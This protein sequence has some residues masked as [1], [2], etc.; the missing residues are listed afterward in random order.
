[1]SPS[2]TVLATAIFVAIIALASFSPAKSQQNTASVDASAMATQPADVEPCLGCH[3]A[4]LAGRPGRTPSL[5]ASGV[6][7]HYT[8]KQFEVVMNTGVTND[9][10]HVRGGM[11]TFHWKASTSDAVYKYLKTLK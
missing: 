3:A 7:K 11:P 1:M 2:A 6:L 5:H 9:G 4:D 10:G 8:K